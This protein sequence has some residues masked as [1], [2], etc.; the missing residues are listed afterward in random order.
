MKK[1]T[2][3]NPPWYFSHPRDI[4]LPQI[5]GLGYLAAYCGSK[6]IQSHVLNAVSMGAGHIRRVRGRYTSYYEVGLSCEE[7]VSRIPPDTDYIGISAPFT[8][9]AGTVKKLGALVKKKFPGVPVILGGVY[10]SLVAGEAMSPGIDYYVVG[11][12]ERPLADIAAGKDPQAVQGVMSYGQ[13]CTDVK[14]AEVVENLDDIPFPVRDEAVL[15]RSFYYS[16]RKERKRS[17]SVITSRGCPYGCA[18]CSIHR[19]TG[20]RWRRRSAANVLDEV[21][22]LIKEFPVDH[23]EFEDDNMTLDRERTF[24]LCEGL[25]KINADGKR[26]SWS[27]P[28][29]VR[30]DTLDRA[31]IALMKRSGCD[32]L[33]F[34]VESGDPDLLKSMDKQLDRDKVIEVVR[35][36]REAGLKTKIM[37]IVGYPGESDR[38]FRATLDFVRTLK[39]SGADEFYASVARAYPGTRL[40]ERC[41]RDNQLPPAGKREDIFLGNVITPGNAL[42]TPDFTPA[43][44]GRRLQALERLTVCLPLRLYHRWHH[45]LKRVIP[46]TWIQKLKHIA[47]R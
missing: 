41:R 6:G 7:L 2:L 31:L 44:L 47:G 3:I 32:S 10:P 46:D 21:R 20:S 27:T 8:N 17:V 35:Q 37:L 43:K 29:G 39:R 30:A 28:N 26:L 11:E 34:G 5:L 4:I 24:L 22:Y 12:G 40:F 25:E 16:P 19:M 13:V 9:S 36:C 23:I 1:V 38:S 33:T 45:L 14:S 42:V 15:C 18:F